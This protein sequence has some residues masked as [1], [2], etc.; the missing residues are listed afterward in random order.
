MF[1]KI[2]IILLTF[3]LNYYAPVVYAE[4]NIISKLHNAD[5]LFTQKQYT[6]S[7]DVYE[8]MLHS[9]FYT[10]R[11]LIR[12]SLIKEGL[13]DYTYALYY[14]NQYYSKKPNKQVLKKMDELAGR[15]NLKGYEYNDLEFFMSYYDRY[16][17][18]ILFVFIAICAMLLLF[19][20][21]KIRNK[22]TFK[23]IAVLL[24]LLGVTFYLTNFGIHSKKAIVRNDVSIMSAPSA[25]ADLIGHTTKGHRIVVLGQEDIWC[26]IKLQDKIGYVR[27][28]N[29][30]FIHP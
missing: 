15:Y 9:G 29:L 6:E 3:I 28:H 2:L 8:N 27:E 19:T 10:P 4:I 17:R 5:S 11:M 12:L 30:L 20:F 26:K 23:S 25:G 14:L 21:F 18:Y 13:G 16:Y 24:L 7:M 1:R 22:K